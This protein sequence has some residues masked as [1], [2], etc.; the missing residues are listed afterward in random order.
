MADGKNSL[1]VEQKEEYFDHIQRLR[2]EAAQRFTAYYAQGMAPDSTLSH[3]RKLE[4]AQA[5]FFTRLDREVFATYKKLVGRRLPADQ[6]E[7]YLDG[8]VSWLAANNR[9]TAG[10][11]QATE[12]DFPGATQAA[13]LKN[14]PGLEYTL[15]SISAGEHVAFPEV[16][17]A[18][19]VEISDEVR[20]RPQTPA[21]DSAKKVPDRPGTE[22][23]QG[24][25]KVLKFTP[26]GKK[27]DEPKND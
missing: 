16:P 5:E 23:P 21:P 12:L 24:D 13:G 19:E 10:A 8:F 20:V 2:H 9:T 3:T 7:P 15:K 26:R 25:G 22:Q 17:R 4:Y 11:Q 14:I 18:P 1:T 6:V 27:P